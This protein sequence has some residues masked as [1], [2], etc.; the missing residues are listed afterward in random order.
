MTFACFIVLTC[1]F[2]NN[3]KTMNILIPHHW[4]LEHLTTKAKPAELQKYLSL[5]GPSVERIEEKEGDQVY[6]I[7]VTTNRVDSMNVRGIAREAAVILNQFQIKAQLKALALTKPSSPNSSLPLPKIKNDPQLCHRTICVVL[8][9]L[10]RTPTPDWMAK[11]LRQ[12]D[13]QVHESIIDITNY[14]TH[15]LGHPIHAFDY[16]QVMAL[17]GEII[18]TTAKPGKKFTTLDGEQYT[19]VGG[20]VVFENPQG[21]IIDLP[22]IKGTAN[23]SVNAKTKNLLLWIENLDPAKVR[24]ASMTHAIRTMAAQLGEKRVDPHLAKPV[25]LKG[26][27]LYQQL[28]QAQIASKIYDD[29]PGKRQLPPVKITTQQLTEYL[30]VELP[31]KKVITIL[32][33]LGCEVNIQDLEL[34]VQPP[35]F[36]PDLKIPADLI[37]EIARIY[38]YHNLS[39]VVMPTPIPLNKPQKVD[40]HLEDQLKQFLAHLGWQEVYTYSMVSKELAQQSGYSLTNHLKLA[41]PLTED[42]V[43]LRRSLIPSLTEVIS[44]NP[45][46]EQLAVFE[47]ANVYQPRPNK[48]PQ[49][50]LHLTLLANKPYRQVKGD[51]EALLRQ[52]YLKDFTVEPIKKPAAAYL[53]AA[54]LTTTKQNKIVKLG[55]IYRLTDQQTAVDLL[56]SN[57]I[58]IAKKHPSYQS[59]PKTS[60]IV[61]DLTFTLPA[62]TLVGKVIKAIKNTDSIVNKVSLT[63]I[64]QHNYTFR[65]K[66]WHPAKNLSK[67][68]VSPVRKKLI[69]NLAKK[70]QA[71]LV[72]EV[73]LKH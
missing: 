32:T 62:K 29:F 70:F 34:V 57:L 14:L 10:Q 71:D 5:C 35:T 3:F 68:D 11:K 8:K 22:M 49:H 69:K 12:V 40:F 64:Y 28:C 6:D 59:L 52:I 72:G 23:T 27:E 20:E 16:D 55:Q 45:Q 54:T 56:M 60:Q 4:L 63:T 36:R 65:L 42:R 33:D 58:G 67:D 53:Q 37:E 19:T 25:L 7:E 13:L 2:Y 44:Q 9:D 30:G 1:D 48:I 43:Y 31:I 38:G 18:I 26:I 73:E 21:E 41:N 47:L 51:L 50:Q 24:F 61:E 17:G 15:E 66:Y 46:Q 39:S